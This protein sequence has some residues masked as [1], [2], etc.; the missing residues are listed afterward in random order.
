MDRILFNRRLIL[1]FIFLLLVIRY[2]VVQAQT[3]GPIT[4]KK[5][6]ISLAEVFKSIKKQ[7][8]L[9]VFYSNN[10]LNDKEL[11]TVDFKSAELKEVF[12]VLLKGK[13]LN[14]VLRDQLIVIEKSEP[15][16][17]V[18]PSKKEPS[19]AVIPKRVQGVVSDD[20]GLTLPGVSVK[21]KGTMNGT[22]SDVDGKYTLTLKEGGSSIIVFSFVGSKSQEFDL[23]NYSPSA[24]GVYKINVQMGADKN[25]LEEVAVVA[26]GTQKKTSLVSS[27]T[28]V[29]PKQLKGPSSNLTTM[30]AGVV[31]G[32]I[33]YQR[34][35][36][37]GAD[38][39]QFFIRGVG[40]FGA[41]KVD[42][43]ILIDGIE[44]STT[45]LARLQPDD[46]SGFSV[47]KDATA[48][49]LYGARG[50][51]GVILVTTKRGDVGAVKFNIRGENSTSSNIKNIDLADNI[52]YM[53][54][55]NEAVLTRNPLGILPYSQNK[56]DHTANGDD[57][58]LYPS[59]NWIKQLI[60]TKTNNQRYNMNASGGSEKAK[61]YL[62]MTY[63]IDN[64]NLAENS[65]NNFSNN[66]KLQSYSILSNTTLNLT[67]T[68]EA[69]VSLKGQFD[70]YHGPINGGGYTFLNALW[71]NP[72][73]FPA[74]Y[75]GNLLPYAS[76]PLFGN[77][78]IPGGGLYMNPYAQSLSGY[79]TSNTSTLT[80]QLNLSQKLDFITQGLSS[81]VMAYTTRYS[82]FTVSRQYSPY[83]YQ[84]NVVNGQFNGLTL[85][86]SG[87]AGSVGPTPTEYLTYSP[88]G[89]VSNSTTYIEAAVNYNRTFGQKHAV[90]GL[91]IG[92]MRN[93]LTANA[94]TLQLSLPS[95]NQGVS[96]RFTY[97]YDNRYLVEFN[98]GYNG[99]ERFAS[100]H[101]F[102]FFPSVGA[103][104]VV[105]NEKFFEPLLSTIDNLKF[106]FT[107]GLVGNDQIGSS[108]DRFFYLSDVNLN[109]GS[110]GQFGTNYTY[111]RPG[112]VTNRY[113]NQNITWEQSRQTNIG[114]DLTVAKNFTLTVDAYQQKR[115][116]ILMVRSTIPTSMGLQANISSNAGKSSSRGIDIAMDYKKSF[117]NSFWVQSRGT[118]T[119]S[120]SKLLKN[121]EPVYG[122]DLKYL[123]KVG[124]SLSQIYGLVAER[125]F[126]DDKDVA[127]SPVQSFGD[128]KAGDIKYRDMN[129][130]GKISSSD[131]VPIGYPIVPE[132]IYGFGFSFGYK[133]FDISAF[134]QGSA[135]SSFVINSADISP[136]YLVNGLQPNLLNTGNQSGL[137]S[138]IANDHWS[139]DNRNPYAFWPRLSTN[140]QGNNTQTSTWWLRNGSFVRL[141]SA[142]LGY[143]FT[144]N[145]LKF[146]HLS[147]ARIYL[148]GLN[149]LT[150]SSFKLWDPE[151]GTSGLGYP[152]QKVFNVG[153]R[154]E[155]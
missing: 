24:T 60:K 81:R 34:S 129:G 73:A 18:A 90:S 70:S 131:V 57:P 76:H 58:L 100:N 68:T 12:G 152:I 39:A 143:N 137:L 19:G 151:M 98:F 40:T 101:R 96:G 23:A 139:E 113:E 84:S 5:A 85:L 154:V 135:R 47:L 108:N 38:N 74:I 43:L 153:L 63:N 146:I 27:I 69:V 106:R 147:S 10:L 51:N 71:S 37:P 134:F 141:K 93:Y 30:L 126:I 102:G 114:M 83:Y 86:N 112:I 49:S 8:G 33:S 149:L 56:I 133:N 7:T 132:I 41:G 29:N 21:V 111:S 89:S 6:N 75:P 94:P 92:T 46:I 99:S 35:G 44:S 36:E 124:N 48:S 87:A 61:Y 66:I 91:L 136:F 52:T 103:G 67:K 3:T 107:Y 32:M 55:A 122:D 80:A 118:L 105:S 97:G 144:K 130:D 77:A 45:D 53:T 20:K 78:L 138:T 26:Y 64:G 13:N 50:A 125:L 9:T 14:Y 148:N 140:I 16:P 128:Y 82:Y 42:P 142:E 1:P 145:Q 15:A 110:Y 104:W 31:P 116:N 54:L 115:D 127:N 25:A 155:F 28:T 150:L 79:Q 109:N 59:N 2:G 117:S 62:A 120:K 123:S 72:V 88:G 11:V 119:Y 22:Q 95:R 17:V 4:L 65:L 121:E